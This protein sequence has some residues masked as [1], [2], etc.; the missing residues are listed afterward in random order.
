MKIKDQT[1]AV[2]LAFLFGI[3]LTVGFICVKNDIEY[4]GKCPALVV[5]DTWGHNYC[6]NPESNL[7]KG[8]K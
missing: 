1:V 5:T 3:V 6:I 7:L 2:I 4:N 8:D